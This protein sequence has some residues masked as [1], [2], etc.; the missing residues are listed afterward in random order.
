MRVH[1]GPGPGR[2]LQARVR[3]PVRPA[4]NATKEFSSRAAMHQ[5]AIDI[6]SSTQRRPWLACESQQP[7]LRP[8]CPHAPRI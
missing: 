5:P 4:R 6:P 2:S 1:G 8:T 3:A 7:Q